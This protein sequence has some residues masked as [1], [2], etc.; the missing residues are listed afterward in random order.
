MLSVVRIDSS[1]QS[2]S[3]NVLLEHL[4]KEVPELER[5]DSRV[6]NENQGFKISFLAGR[7]KFILLKLD[8][9]RGMLFCD[10]LYLFLSNS[11]KITE[12]TNL[13]IKDLKEAIQQNSERVI[14]GNKESLMQAEAIASAT[15][16][17]SRNGQV[18][19]P[20]VLVAMEEFLRHTN[21]H[22]LQ[23]IKPLRPVIIR[24]MNAMEVKSAIREDLKTDLF[25]VHRDHLQLHFKLKDIYELL[26]EYSFEKDEEKIDELLITQDVKGAKSHLFDLIDSYSS[27]FEE[28]V[29]ELDQMDEL[30][31][32]M[33]KL[34][35][36]SY[37]ETRNSLARVSIY[38]NIVTIAL[39]FSNLISSSFGMNLDNH[40]N[41]SYSF[42]VTNLVMVTLTVVI[43]VVG[44]AF[45]RERFKG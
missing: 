15:M 29:E 3:R 8:Y 2:L 39:S 21:E 43:I 20:F 19:R 24:M 44:V 17:K 35:N 41:Y 33:I 6:I 9:L 40:L 14:D 38:L 25:R 4:L 36:T 23:Q 10:Y 30:L 5:R 27:Y 7:E 18:A 16:V 37:S 22:Y 42:L 13:F 1:G 26:H 45:F 28:L 32:L 34:V 12:K 11:Q 31:N